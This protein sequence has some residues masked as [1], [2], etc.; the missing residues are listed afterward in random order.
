MRKE[1]HGLANAS[2]CNG[3]YHVSKAM[4][5]CLVSPGE[6]V[7]SLES[8]PIWNLATCRSDVIHISHQGSCLLLF[9][10]QCSTASEV[11][12]CVAESRRVQWSPH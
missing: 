11:R 10:Q 3:V 5:R 1:W 9:I 8:W 6:G 7:R 4:W 2:E 12:G